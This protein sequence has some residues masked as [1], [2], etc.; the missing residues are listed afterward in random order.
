[1]Q[2]VMNREG[3]G[4]LQFI[5]FPS[6]IR[7]LLFR[8]KYFSYHRMTESQQMASEPLMNPLPKQDLLLFLVE[9]SALEEAS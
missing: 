9:A 3:A 5:W 7:S 1:M 4:V 6:K 2:W 8:G